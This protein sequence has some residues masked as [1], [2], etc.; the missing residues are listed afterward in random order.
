[1]EQ[2]FGLYMNDMRSPKIEHSNLV[3][4]SR[5]RAALEKLLKD[6]RCEP[7]KDERVPF[8]GIGP[9][10]WSKNHRKGGPLEW[11][12]PLQSYSPEYG[13]GIFDM[14]AD[15]LHALNSTPEIK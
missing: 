14:T 13:Q 10:H 15:I 6:E 1:M 3:C 2:I 8:L 5:S 12:N 4:W 9:S 7:Y 11:Y